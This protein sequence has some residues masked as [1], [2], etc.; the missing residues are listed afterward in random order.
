MTSPTSAVGAY[1]RSAVGAG[2]A[3]VTRAV[4]VLLL[5]VLVASCTSLPRSGPVQAAEPQIPPGYGVD[6]L[7]EGP[8]QNASPEEIVN[9]FL[10]ASAYGHGDEFQ[11][12]SQY[13]AP[14]VTWEPLAQVRVYSATQSPDIAVNANDGGISVTV[15]QVAAVDEVGRY[16]AM[17]PTTLRST[18]TL[19][20]TSEEQWRIAGLDAGLLVSDVNFEQT[21]SVASLYFLTRDFSATVPELRWY[22]LEDRAT[23]IVEGIL[24][25]PSGWMERGVTSAFPQG[26][27]LLRQV[28]VQDGVATIHLSDAFLEAGD[29]EIALANAQLENTLAAVTEIGSIE[30]QVRG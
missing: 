6:V 27:T 7:A 21:F 14:G 28:A 2:A 18:F 12:A 25:G 15:E 3:R 22:P 8:A 26:T 10:R 1:A 20:R 19:V 4:A 17:S 30:L 13:L 5:A 29:Q 11:V 23:H 9:G 16:E 24:A